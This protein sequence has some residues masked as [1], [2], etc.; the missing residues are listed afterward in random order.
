MR[1]SDFFLDVKIDPQA[2]M[3]ISELKMTYCHL[4]NFY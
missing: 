4:K 1:L 2:L 3:L